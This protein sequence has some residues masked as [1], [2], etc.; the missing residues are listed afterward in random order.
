MTKRKPADQKL[1]PGRKT[2]YRPEYCAE[3]VRL[4]KQ[5]LSRVEIADKFDVVRMTLEN[6]AAAHPPFLAALTRADE[7][8]EAL[9]TRL[10][11]DGMAQR[12]FNAAVWKKMMECRW[13]ENWTT[14]NRNELTGK[15]GEPIRVAHSRAAS[16]ID[17]LAAEVAAAVDSATESDDAAADA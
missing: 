8:A 16:L 5:G 17:D 1:K 10:G 12:D 3:V 4:G 13:R 11:R 2:V 6:W 7:A 15:D 9:H 14:I